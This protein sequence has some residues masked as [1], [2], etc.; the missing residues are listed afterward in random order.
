MS[1]LIYEQGYFNKQHKLRYLSGFAARS[2][3]T[4]GRVFLKSR[5]YEELYAK[6]LYD[7][8][9]DEIKQVM[10]CLNPLNLHASRQSGGVIH[11]YIQWAMKEGLR[12][13]PTNPLDGVGKSWY[14][15]FIDTSKEIVF[16]EAQIR[17]IVSSLNNYQDACIIQMLYEGVMGE[18]YS[19]LLNLRKVDIDQDNN[20][21]HLRNDNGR[22]RKLN[23]SDLCIK[24]VS[25]A[26]DETKYLK[27]NG[28]VKPG[29]KS[30]YTHLVDNDYVLKISAT[31][32]KGNGRGDKHLVLRRMKMVST[33]FNLD[34]L[35]GTNVRFSGMLS[36]ARDVYAAG[37]KLELDEL[38]AMVDRFDISSLNNFYIYK[39]NFLNEATIKKVY[40]L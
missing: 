1:N 36:M 24:L 34:Y 21:L 33:Y 39:T 27:N 28:D 9:E 19:E 3:S 35:T 22:E 8:N 20:L 15:Q 14:G 5:M 30:P 37:K 17:D 16:S 10:S 29:T 25:A 6:D 18:G 2:Q 13:A 4:Y 40:G 26:L 38:T 7:F 11:N 31:R 12:C 32:N 23:V